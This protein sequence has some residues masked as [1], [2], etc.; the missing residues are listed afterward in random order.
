VPVAE[1]EAHAAEEAESMESLSN[2]G[3]VDAAL[4]E[5]FHI[6]FLLLAAPFTT[7]DTSG[8]FLAIASLTRA[9][10][11]KQDLVKE[12]IATGVPVAEAEA[13]AAEEAESMEIVI[14]LGDF[15]F[16]G[17][18]LRTSTAA[19]TTRVVVTASGRTAIATGVP[20]A[21]AEAHAAE[22]AESMES[23]SNVGVVANHFHIAFLLLAAPFTTSDTSG[24]FLAIASLTRDI[25]EEAAR[26]RNAIWKPSDRAALTATA[27]T[28]AAVAAAA[29][30]VSR[31]R[32]SL[33][34]L[35][36]K[37]EPRL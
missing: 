3:V 35:S 12:A 33:E 1:A 17:L 29:A 9:K 32:A 14:R 16:L 5:G 4:S 30:M 18:V 31:S 13:H 10:F 26:R 20:V 6:A 15:D 21:E 8:V 23:L 2:V 19:T 28:T 11:N 24:V 37:E 36:K 22:E 27:P 25:V 34:I 7:S